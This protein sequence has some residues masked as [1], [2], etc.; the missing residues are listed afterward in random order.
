MAGYTAPPSANP[1]QTVAVTLVVPTVNCK[2]TPTGGFQAVLAGAVFEVPVGI[3]VAE[4]AWSARTGAHLHPVHPDQ[5]VVDRER[6]HP[7]CRRHHLHGRLGRA[8]WY[9][10]HGPRRRAYPDGQRA[11]R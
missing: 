7:A 4:P 3:P 1:T 10:G 2:K 6:D 9:L 8:R 5:R 11:R